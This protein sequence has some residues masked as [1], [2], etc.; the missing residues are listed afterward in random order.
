MTLTLI[1]L[2]VIL[3][4]VG[5]IT[6]QNRIIDSLKNGDTNVLYYTDQIDSLNADLWAWFDY[7]KSIES[8]YDSLMIDYRISTGTIESHKIGTIGYNGHGKGIYAMELPLSPDLPKGY[9]YAND[10]QGF[11]VGVKDAPKES[12]KTEQKSIVIAPVETVE[13]NA[14]Q[15]SND[16]GM[17]TASDDSTLL[18]SAKYG[19]LLDLLLADQKTKKLPQNQYEYVKTKFLYWEH[20]KNPNTAT[21]YAK[22]I[23]SAKF[24]GK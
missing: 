23:I 2:I 11:I 21:E 8:K 20:S 10:D 16:A 1:A 9:H 12:K 24:G 5:Y 7:A 18:K 13:T 4:L 14:V 19:E 15:S 17:F 6:Y 22:R 3:A